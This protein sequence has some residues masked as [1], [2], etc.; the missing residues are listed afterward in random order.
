MYNKIKK[1]EKKTSINHV[2]K[3]YNNFEKKIIYF[4][5]NKFY[6]DF[7]KNVIHQ[8]HQIFIKTI[9]KYLLQNENNNIVEL[10]SG[11]GSKI[12]N[13]ANY[14]NKY[15]N[16]INYH[17]GEF[18][19]N[20]RKIINRISNDSKLNINIFNFNFLDINTYKSIPTNSIIF[21]SYSVH[22]IKKLNNNF[23]NFLQSTDPKIII[24]F[25]PLFESHKINSKYANMCRNYISYNGYCV[26]Q[27]SFLKN[28][29]KLN[30]IKIISLKKNIFGSNPFFP[31]SEI[32][33]R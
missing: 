33:W 13:I 31:I 15:Y 18:S 4:D 19:S 32:I 30:K 23:I 25:E 10:G 7:T 27:L 20:G 16:N 3:I 12:M 26:N 21:T 11:Y 5:N 24:N 8:Y 9:S 22:Y 1:I 6:K 28:K 29:H 14:L 2:D 17:A